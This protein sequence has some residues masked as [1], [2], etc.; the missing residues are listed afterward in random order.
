MFLETIGALQ[1][2]HPS[3]LSIPCS[4]SLLNIQLNL[5]LELSLDSFMSTFIWL[6]HLSLDNLSNMIFKYL[7]NLFNPKDSTNAFTQ[8]S[9][10][11]SYILMSI[12]RALNIRS[13]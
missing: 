10:V 6:S 9:Q 12:A 13:F 3:D 8:I 11:G 7:Q 5:N 2:L 1:T 4:N